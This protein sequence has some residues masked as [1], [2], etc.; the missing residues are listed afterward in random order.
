MVRGPSRASQR[1]A[2]CKL[3]SLMVAWPPPPSIFFF[4]PPQSNNNRNER[5][6]FF[7]C[8]LYTIQNRTVLPGRQWPGTQKIEVTKERKCY[9]TE[10]SW[11][12]FSSSLLQCCCAFCREWPRELLIRW[13]RS[14][15]KRILSR[16]LGLMMM[17]SLGRF[18][19]F[20]FFFFSFLCSFP[21]RFSLVIYSSKQQSSSTCWLFDRPHLLLLGLALLGC[22]PI[23]VSLLFYLFYRSMYIQ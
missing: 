18:F 2:D 5:V 14:Y 1:T 20:F 9:R 10:Y 13:H 3:C 11:S 15:K 22:V 8:A 21:L 4:Y 7:W 12:I 6:L 23:N 17:P 16:H 19:F